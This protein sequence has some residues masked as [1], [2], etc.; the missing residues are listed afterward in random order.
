MAFGNR[1]I[2]TSA[3]GG[4]LLNYRFELFTNDANKTYGAGLRLVL[5]E[6]NGS[7]WDEFH[8]VRYGSGYD[9]IQQYAPCVAVPEGNLVKATFTREG[10]LL[11]GHYFVISNRR[12]VDLDTPGCFTQQYGTY[13]S[14]CQ[15]YTAEATFYVTTPAGT[16]TFP[17]CPPL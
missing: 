14:S 10:G 2:N 4:G 1:L 11:G 16:Q 12:V 9:G 6:W 17:A 8:N 13:G 15:S 5:S 7:S 3:G